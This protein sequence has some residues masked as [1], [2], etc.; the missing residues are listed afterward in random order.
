MTAMKNKYV[1]MF[2]LL[3]FLFSIS[4]IANETVTIVDE[5]G[6]VQICKVTESGVIVC[7]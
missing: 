1:L 4:A 6:D 7:L 3:I 2:S 5:N